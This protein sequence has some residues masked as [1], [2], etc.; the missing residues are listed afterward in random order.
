M[1]DVNRVRNSVTIEYNIGPLE[2][3][4]DL[5]IRYDIKPVVRNNLVITFGSH[6]FVDVPELQIQYAIKNQVQKEFELGFN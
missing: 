2:V 1:P 6:K 4:R 5:N 3:S